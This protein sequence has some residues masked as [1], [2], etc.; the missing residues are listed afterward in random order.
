MWLLMHRPGEVPLEN[1]TAVT[2]RLKNPKTYKNV[3][4]VLHHGLTQDSDALSAQD[5]MPILQQCIAGSVAYH[6]IRYMHTC[7]NSIVYV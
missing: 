3:D 4:L 5:P 1:S 6:Q 7:A 2:C